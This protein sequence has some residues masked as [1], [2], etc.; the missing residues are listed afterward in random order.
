MFDSPSFMEVVMFYT[1]IG[2]RETPREVMVV[3]YHFAIQMAERGLILR[4]G[5]ALRSEI[6]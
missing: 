3:M 1:G 5:G 2:S 4:S 6:V